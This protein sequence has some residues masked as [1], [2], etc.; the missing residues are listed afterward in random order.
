MVFL[1]FIYV[2]SGC[3]KDTDITPTDSNAT[4]RS[5]LSERSPIIVGDGGQRSSTDFG[6]NEGQNVLTVMG[7]PR[8]NPFS[9]V[10]M[11]GAWNSLYKQNRVTLPKTHT[12]IKAKPQRDKDLETFRKYTLQNKIPF[13]DFP[14]DYEVISMGDYYVDPSITKAEYIYQYAVIPVGTNLPNV[15][16]DIIDDLLLAPYDGVYGSVGNFAINSDPQFVAVAEG[17]AFHYGHFMID[18]LAF[19]ENSHF[20]F[21]RNGAGVLVNTGFI[22]LGLGID[23]IDPR[24]NNDPSGY[25]DQVTGFT[26]SQYFW[27]LQSNV[28]TMQGLRNVY[29]NSYL[30]TTTNTAEQVNSLFNQ[31]NF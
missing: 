27:A 15:P 5:S 1:C 2:I 16:Y 25:D 13:F 19:L 23:L 12:Y 26:N 29:L 22:P 11:T 3:N 21:A 8:I 30:G 14:L 31:Y 7:K 17:W 24:R 6:R 4:Y 10:N 9:V 28:I 18:D 20:L